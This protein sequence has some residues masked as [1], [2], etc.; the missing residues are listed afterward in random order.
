MSAVCIAEGFVAFS[1][2]GDR[3]FGEPHLILQLIRV[4]DLHLQFF[5]AVVLACLLLSSVRVSIR[6]L[7]L[8]V[9]VRSR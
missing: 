8:L 7:L 6:L 1:F 4:Q 5:L 9:G 3:E 2:I